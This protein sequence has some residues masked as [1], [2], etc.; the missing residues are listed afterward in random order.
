MFDIIIILILYFILGPT[1]KKL[2]SESRMRKTPKKSRQIA[3]I[4]KQ[5]DIKESK[6]R[7]SV[8]TIKEINLN[9]K[10]TFAKNK[11]LKNKVPDSKSKAKKLL[12][13][14]ELLRAVILKEV[15]STPKAFIKRSPY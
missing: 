11:D 3:Q 8:Q 15:L 4:H 12:N 5:K 1:L 13:K 14:N 9:E 10:S 7:E 6:T 2:L